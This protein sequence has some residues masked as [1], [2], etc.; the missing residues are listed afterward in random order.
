[1]VARS[2]GAVVT[3]RAVLAARI[4][5]D[6]GHMFP[7]FLDGAYANSTSTVTA[8]W[9]TTDNVALA[10]TIIHRQ[11]DVK[12]RQWDPVV[13]GTF[14]TVTVASTDTRSGARRPVQLAEPEA[15]A[16]A[17]FAAEFDDDALGA[18]L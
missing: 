13:S 3:D 6:H 1:M 16:R 14:V 7:S 15:W 9:L 18:V 4:R 8:E 2:L 10:V 5:Q 17:V 11:F 12:P